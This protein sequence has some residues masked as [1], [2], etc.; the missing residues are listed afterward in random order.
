M[1][2]PHYTEIRVRRWRFWPKVRIGFLF[3]MYAWFLLFDE[4]G[5]EL[6]NLK[7]QASKQIMF[8]AALSSAR[9][10]G[11]K[12]W[13]NADDIVKFLEDIPAR[14]SNKVLKTFR[15]SQTVIAEFNERIKGEK[16]K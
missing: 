11:K 16:K 5:I 10:T 1:K 14:E 12:E 9:N 4:F 15:E 7:D 13:F 2:V 6:D 8:A 3:D